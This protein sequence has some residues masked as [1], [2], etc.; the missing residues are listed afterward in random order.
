MAAGLMQNFHRE[1]IILP[2]EK[3]IANGVAKQSTIGPATCSS[4]QRWHSSVSTL[5]LR[6]VGI[7]G[8]IVHHLKAISQD[9]IWSTLEISYILRRP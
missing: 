9:S 3:P 7:F 8:F 1:S 6:L 5:I 4:H 2:N